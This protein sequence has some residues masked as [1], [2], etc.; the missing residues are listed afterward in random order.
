VRGFPADRARFYDPFLVRGTLQCSQLRPSYQQC[1][2]HAVET[3]E[4]EQG[5]FFFFFFFFFLFFFSFFEGGRTKGGGG[6][7]LFFFISF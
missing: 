6:E 5:A 2:L 4:G 7:P 3:S 1:E